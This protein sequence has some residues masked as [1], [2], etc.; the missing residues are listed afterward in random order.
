MV[1]AARLTRQRRAGPVPGGSPCVRAKLRTVGQQQPA[2][3]TMMPTKLREIDRQQ[4]DRDVQD[5]DGDIERRCSV[6]TTKI[7]DRGGDDDREQWQDDAH[8]GRCHDGGR[9]EGNTSGA[10]TVYGSASGSRQTDV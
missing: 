8:P 1:I 3:T 9:H 2:A 6:S 5:R 4:D 7:E 10:G